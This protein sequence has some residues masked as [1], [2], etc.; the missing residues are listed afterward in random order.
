MGYAITQKK[1]GMVLTVAAAALA[2]SGCATTGSVKRAQARADDAYAQAES[3]QAI[4]NHAQGSADAA[5]AA[6]GRAQGSADAANQAAQSAGALAS[7]AQSTAQAAAADARAARAQVAVLSSRL[8]KLEAGKAHRH[9]KGRHHT[10]HT[11]KVNE[12]QPAQF[13]H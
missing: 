12:T 1:A 9:G 6:A 3:G 8:H 2:L 4:G 5:F 11:M 7:G 13:H 10:K